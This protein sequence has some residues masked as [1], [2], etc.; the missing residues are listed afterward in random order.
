VETVLVYFKFLKEQK[1]VETK[2][3]LNIG[4]S[5]LYREKK[6]ELKKEKI[7][8]MKEVRN[9]S[10]LVVEVFNNKEEVT[11]INKNRI[12]IKNRTFF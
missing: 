5:S 2:T 9:K 3:L 4:A 7:E 11:A 1:D 6:I 8:I 10:K 12:R